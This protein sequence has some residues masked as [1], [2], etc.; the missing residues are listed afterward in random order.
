MDRNLQLALDRETKLVGFVVR[1]MIQGWP[2]TICFNT[3]RKTIST[4]TIVKPSK[5]LINPIKLSKPSPSNCKYLLPSSLEAS[6]RLRSPCT[7]TTKPQPLSKS[8]PAGRIHPP[9]P[10]VHRRQHR[11]HCEGITD[12]PGPIDRALLIW[13]SAGVPPGSS[14]S[15]LPNLRTWLLGW[16]W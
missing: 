11:P 14:S 8:T 10:H 5:P 12:Y 6:N 15:R 4:I 1:G 2:Y 9:P 13:V 3:Q 16:W 7:G